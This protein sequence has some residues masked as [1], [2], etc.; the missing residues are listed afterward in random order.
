MDLDP[1]TKAYLKCHETVREI[2]KSHT[3]RH[4]KRYKRLE[5]RKLDKY[6]HNIQYKSQN[7][8]A[9]G[10]Q[11]MSDLIVGHA[12]PNANHRTTIL[13]M[14]LFFESIDIRFPGYD[15]RA[16]RER[17]IRECNEYIAKSKRILHSRRHDQRYGKKHMEMTKSWL[18]EVVGDQ[19]NSSGMMSRK[20]LTTLRKSSASWNVSSVIVK[21]R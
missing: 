19:S 17:W 20:S 6:F 4:P 3:G 13:F 7:I 12:L 15:T 14:A 9:F 1:L 2:I 18:S 10:A 21:K 11:T 5:M 8:L 16:N